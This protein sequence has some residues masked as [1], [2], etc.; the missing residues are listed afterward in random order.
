MN[1]LYMSLQY[2]VICNSRHL[3]F[4]AV[5]DYIEADRLLSPAA[6]IRETRIVPSQKA[7][8]GTEQAFASHLDIPDLLEFEPRD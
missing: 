8:I 7:Q 3:T 1:Y 2:G 6:V 4:Q 5:S